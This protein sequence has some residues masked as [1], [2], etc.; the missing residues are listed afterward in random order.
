MFVLSQLQGRAA[1][2]QHGEDFRPYFSVLHRAGYD[3]RIVIECHWHNI[4][5]EVDTA[6]AVLREQWAAT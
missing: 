6:L 2:G 4:A 5:A 1:P 3:Q